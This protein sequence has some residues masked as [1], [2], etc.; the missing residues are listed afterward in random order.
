MPK[1]NLDF[2]FYLV[3]DSTMI[4][5]GASFLGQVEQAVENGATLVQ[6]REK[7]ILTRDFIDRARQ[8]LEITRP[9]GV[10]LIINDR[11]DVALAVDAEGVHVGQDD[12]P[13]TLVRK[14][15]GPDKIL[16]VSCCSPEETAQVCEE[17]VADY[18][19]LGTCYPTST[20]DVKSVVGPIGI[21]KLLHVLK[22]HYDKGNKRI[23]SVAIGGI[24]HSNAAKVLYQCEIGGNENKFGIDGLAIVSCI[25]AAKDA[26]EASKSFVKAM[27]SRKRLGFTAMYNELSYSRIDGTCIRDVKPLVHHITN[28]VVKNF[29]A[30]V[31][32]AIG[33]SPIMSELSA[34]FSELANLDLAV[35]LLINLGTPNFTSMEVFMEALRAYNEAGR[36]VVFDPVAAGATTPRLEACRALLNAGQ[37]DVIKGNVGEIMAIEKLTSTYMP[38]Q[39]T[40]TTMKGVD[41]ISKASEDQIIAVASRVSEDFKSIVVVTGKTNYV[42]YALGEGIFCKKIAGGHELMASVTGT[43]CSLGSVITA[44]IACAQRQRESVVNAVVFAIAF[45]N[46]AGQFAGSSSGPGS[47][48]QKFLDQLSNPIVSE[49]LRYNGS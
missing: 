8:I 14:I 36:P 16:G 1:D 34:E 31:T 46:L 13:A 5:E 25:M 11:V 9:R 3:T 43:G 21:R 17:G 38:P 42:V 33:A 26:A 47:F 15:I 35:G 48:S 19:G 4:P 7:K 40:E 24:N 49:K 10:P 45:Y 23:A 32:L 41:S 44:Y 2:S 20:K 39:V 12:M 6:L 18:V 29:S 28:N 27:L 37:F 22:R 30:N